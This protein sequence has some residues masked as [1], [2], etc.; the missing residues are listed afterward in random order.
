M[1]RNT[2]SD[3]EDDP[4]RDARSQTSQHAYVSQVSQLRDTP[5]PTVRSRRNQNN[6]PR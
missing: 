6:L 5:Y 1:P 2:H 4:S 3:M